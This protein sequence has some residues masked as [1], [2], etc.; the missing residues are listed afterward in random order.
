M[1]FD[2]YNNYLIKILEEY[3]V[4]LIKTIQEYNIET[5]CEYISKPFDFNIF[6]PLFLVLCLLKIITFKEFIFLSFSAIIIYFIKPILKR[7]RPCIKYTEIKN[8]SNINHI[9]VDEYKIIKLKNNLY[10]FPSG[11]ATISIVFYLIMLNKFNLNQCYFNQFNL[12]KLNLNKY[13]VL[14][15]TIPILVGFS[16]VYLGVHYPSDVIGGFIVGYL[17]FNIIKSEL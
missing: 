13:K 10:S 15:S 11:H 3:D 4:Y 2:K 14:L 17:Y 6:I 1:I 7:T 8:K 5:L 9:N 16:R 12:N